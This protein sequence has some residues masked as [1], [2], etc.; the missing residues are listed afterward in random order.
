MPPGCVNAWSL[1][2]PP[3]AH[4]CF[5]LVSLGLPRRER[6]GQGPSS[7]APAWGALTLQGPELLLLLCLG[8]SPS[9][10]GLGSS[11]EMHVRTVPYYI[12]LVA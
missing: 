4:E 9:P 12:S 5:V 3:L 11:L 2:R 10:C 7:Q 8:V 1:R 6:D